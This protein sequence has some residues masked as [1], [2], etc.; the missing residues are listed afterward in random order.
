MTSPTRRGQQNFVITQSSATHWR[1]ATCQEEECAGYLLGFQTV[2]P[3]GGDMAQWIRSTK[4][5]RW[6]EEVTAE[7]I[8]TFRFPPGQDCFKG[9]AGQHRQWAGRPPILSHD[10]RALPRPDDWIGD[11][12]EELHRNERLRQRG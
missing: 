7:G 10:G 11:F 8:S 1:P 6:K 3:T 2:V 4:R 5:W 9:A 12:K